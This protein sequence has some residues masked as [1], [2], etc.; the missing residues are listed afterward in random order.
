MRCAMPDAVLS[1]CTDP[2]VVS[3]GAAPAIITVAKERSYIVNSRSLD[4]DFKT[5]PHASNVAVRAANDTYK[6]L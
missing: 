6:D 5:V 1:R 4:Y 2:A 3:T